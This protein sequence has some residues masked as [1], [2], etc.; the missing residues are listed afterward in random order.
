MNAFRLVSDE[1]ESLRASVVALVHINLAE[2]MPPSIS[3]A[4]R[5]RSVLR[6]ANETHESNW[7]MPEQNNASVTLSGS[8]GGRRLAVTRTASL[9]GEVPSLK[10]NGKWSRGLIDDFFS[11]ITRQAENAD[12]VSSGSGIDTESSMSS[13]IYDVGSPSSWTSSCSRTRLGERGTV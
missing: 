10:R 3:V 7:W 12:A 11:G 2:C 1:D 13:V 9:E 8:D 6:L 4:R 5:F